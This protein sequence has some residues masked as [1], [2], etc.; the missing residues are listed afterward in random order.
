MQT[1][2]FEEAIAAEL[3][4]ALYGVPLSEAVRRSFPRYRSWS[5]VESRKT[6]I[7]ADWWKVTP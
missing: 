6:Y 2:G 7:M 5:C 4:A 3:W 1:T